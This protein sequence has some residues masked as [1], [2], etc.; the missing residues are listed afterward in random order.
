M[1]IHSIGIREVAIFNY[2]RNMKQSDDVILALVAGLVVHLHSNNLLFGWF[3]W[4]NK[5]LFK[6]VES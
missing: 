6:Q 1:D 5:T 3:T 4:L 2:I